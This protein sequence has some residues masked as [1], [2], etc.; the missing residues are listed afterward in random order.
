MPAAVSKKQ[1]R[2][3]QAILHGKAGHT[4]RG[5][6][7]PS[8]AVAAKYV[9]EHGTGK[10]M[11][12]K[13]NLP[14][15]KG[16]EH[17]GGRWDEENKAKDKGRVQNKRHEKN[18]EKKSHKE[19]ARNKKDLKKSFED[20]YKGQAAATLVV[21][22]NGRILLGRHS[23]GGLAF[24]GGHVENGESVE[25]AALRELKEEA[26]VDGRIC[27]TLY[28]GKENGNSAT[29]YLTEIAHGKP[30][31]SEE[32]KDLSWYDASEIPF[33]H[34]RDCCLRPLKQFVTNKLGKTL[35]GMLA[36]E[37]LEKNII[38]QR[39]DAVLEVTHGD[40]LKLVGTGLFRFLKKAVKEMTDEDFRD[41]ELDD[42]KISIRKHMN[43]IYSGRVQDGH[44]VVYQFTNKSLP[45]LT[46]ALMSVFEWYLPDD[47]KALDLLNDDSLKD[48]AIEGGLQALIETHKK[49][50]LGNIYDEM[51]NI[52]KQLRN[53]VAV[54]LQQ[55][56]S[57]MMKLFDKLEETTHHSVD[58]HNELASAVGKDMDELELKLNELRQKL[59]ERDLKP[60]REVV[61]AFSTRPANKD[62]VHSEFY[63]Y[64]SK[65]RVEIQ[66]NGKIIISFS[67]D[68]Q[69]IERENF[70]N[71]M[72]ARVIKKSSNG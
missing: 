49:H 6:G 8:K 10:K 51:E 15:S 43:D 63:S 30:K 47:E 28:N 16:K 50:N 37:K 42:H 9:H 21:D 70:L 5:D 54:D 71:D 39:G 58:K 3:M 20:F 57:R 60:Q 62:K 12:P 45:E 18:K 53:G 31:D 36:I 48:D 65:P 59:G 56:E 13:E 27:S 26:G 40:A 17:E 11:E 69:D 41:I 67:Q 35:R 23:S 34:V 64:L 38:R 29:V 25:G 1:Y 32:L 72:R 52:R 44:K 55:V 2:M 33:D 22:N 19:K 68:W 61:E 7:G 46:A 14:E 24:P 66:P 4:A